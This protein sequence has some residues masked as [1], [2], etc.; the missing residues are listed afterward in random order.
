LRRART[1]PIGD[2]PTVQLAETGF[3]EAWEPNAGGLLIEDLIDR[4]FV[5]SRNRA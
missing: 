3:D 2:A 5:P 1:E 4:L